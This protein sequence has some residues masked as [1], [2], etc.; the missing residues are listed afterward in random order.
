MIPFTA[1]LHKSLVIT[2][3]GPEDQWGHG[4]VRQGWSLLAAVEMYMELKHGYI[5]TIS[6]TS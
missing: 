6:Q 2:E 5:H 4:Q 1:K 3:G